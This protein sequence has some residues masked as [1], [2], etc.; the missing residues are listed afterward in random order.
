MGQVGTTALATM[1][2]HLC[3]ISTSS[4]FQLTLE[5]YSFDLST[6]PI[7][8]TKPDRTYISPKLGKWDKWAL[9]L[10]RLSWP[11]YT[12][13][14]SLL[15]FSWLS[16]HTALTWVPSQAPRPNQTELTL[17]QSW[18]NGT[19]GHYGFSD[20]PDPSMPDIYLWWVSSDS[21]VLQLWPE[22]LP[23]H[24]DHTKQNLH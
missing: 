17:V 24:N 6:F 21:R 9:R 3:Q 1:L 11:I 19:S 18:E 14:L 5:T 23:K 10:Q 12:K 20:Y 16:R 22:Y 15:S 7:T 4:E 2:I 8:L 13:Y